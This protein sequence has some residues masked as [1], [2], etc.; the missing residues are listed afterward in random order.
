MSQVLA[1]SAM[2]TPD[3]I[4]FTLIADTAAATR[5]T[6]SCPNAALSS[7]ASKVRANGFGGPPVEAMLE[8][9]P[10][11]RLP[12][13]RS[14]AGAGLVLIYDVFDAALDPMR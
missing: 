5:M 8:A 14:D 13:Y 1:H 6:R 10:P 4:R 3:H 2:L 12:N 7:R 9:Q 11:A